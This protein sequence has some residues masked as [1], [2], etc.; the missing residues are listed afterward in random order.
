MSRPQDIPESVW[1]EAERWFD[2]AVSPSAEPRVYRPA[3]DSI[4]R[5]ILAERERCAKIADA[6]A[7]RDTGREI[8]AA[9]RG[10]AA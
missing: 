4:A 7:H 2:I 6:F 1:E 10:D 9:I 5:A 8:A 3:V